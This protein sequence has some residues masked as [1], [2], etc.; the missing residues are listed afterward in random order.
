VLLM[1]KLLLA[2]QRASATDV[3]CAD[4]ENCCS[5]TQIIKK[6]FYNLRNLRI[7]GKTPYG[8]TLHMM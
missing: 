7:G 4:E 1:L 2:G 6:Q 3:D 5:A 8:V